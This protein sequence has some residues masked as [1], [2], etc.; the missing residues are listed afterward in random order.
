MSRQP[1]LQMLS[2][3]RAWHADESCVVDR[4]VRLAEAHADCFERSCRP[5]HLTGSAWVTSADGERH[6]L[7]HHRKLGKWLQPGGH[8]DGQSDLEAVARREAEEETGLTGLETI[9]GAMGLVPLD[10]D[11]HA[12]PARFDPHGNPLEDAHEHHDV[13]FLLRAGNGESL[14]I[15][16]ESHELRWCLPE[17]VRTLTTEHSVLRLLDKAQDRLAKLG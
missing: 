13:R 1:L 11:V 9:P 5:G 10:V 14:I 17:E 16:E 4:I 8:A 6:L 3:Y 15:N 12:I 7:M 2:D